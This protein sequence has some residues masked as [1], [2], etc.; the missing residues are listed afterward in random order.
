MIFRAVAEILSANGAPVLADLKDPANY[1]SYK[2]VPGN[3]YTGEQEPAPVIK[4][5][6]EIGVHGRFMP[7]IHPLDKR[8][9]LQ[10]LEDHLTHK[11]HLP[12]GG[13]IIVDSITMMGTTDDQVKAM[14]LIIRLCAERGWRAIM[15]NQTTNIGGA[16]GSNLLR[17]LPDIVA[18]I[19]RDKG[20]KRILY[21]LKHRFDSGKARYF[22]FSDKGVPM[23]PDFSD[24]VW[25]VEGPAN[26]LELVR[27]FQPHSGQKW[28]E[29]PLMVARYAPRL[30]HDELM[31][32]ASAMYQSPTARHIFKELDD[33]QERRWLA[34]EMGLDW[35]KPDRAFA[36]LAPHLMDADIDVDE[37]V[38]GPYAPKVKNAGE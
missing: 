30:L 9:P 32:T 11:L 37:L 13:W 10:D 3:W 33:A 36:L 12:R 5:F 8:N 2:P 17:F 34:E 23:V 24:D 21:F 6:D 4:M 7:P 22:V 14:M 29:F 15:I 27:A 19:R 28:N 16:R 1:K 31:G 38:F 35:I 20:N 26:N 25:T 18:E